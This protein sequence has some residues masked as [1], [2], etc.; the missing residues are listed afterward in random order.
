MFHNLLKKYVFVMQVFGEAIK[1]AWIK[2]D[3]A[4]AKSCS[5]F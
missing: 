2:A 5:C 4:K 3:K 1:A